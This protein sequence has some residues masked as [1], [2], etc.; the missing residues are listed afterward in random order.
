MK[1]EAGLEPAIAI[2]LHAWIWDIDEPNVLV[3]SADVGQI[4][5]ELF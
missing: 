5:T 2:I 4:K 3:A 1:R